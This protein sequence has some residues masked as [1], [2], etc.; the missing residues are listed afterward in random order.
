M[1]WSERQMLPHVTAPAC[2][3]TTPTPQ[4]FS[5]KSCHGLGSRT[6]RGVSSV[7]FVTTTR[8]VSRVVWTVSVVTL[9]CLVVV[10][11]C[12]PAVWGALVQEM[13]GT[14]NVLANNISMCADRS[15]TYGSGSTRR[16]RSVANPLVARRLAEEAAAERD[17][18]I[19]ARHT[20]RRRCRQR[21]PRRSR[22]TSIR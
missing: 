13:Q 17:E 5:T 14:N 16:V 21:R 1:T 18:N 9:R 8:A 7:D 6:A 10:S 19:E 2:R 4:R 20:P 12:Y 11:P 22:C 3:P 15:D